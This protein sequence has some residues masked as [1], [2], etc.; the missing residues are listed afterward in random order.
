MLDQFEEFTRRFREVFDHPP[1]G[2]TAGEWLFHLR[3]ETRS[4][5]ALDFLTLAASTG[6]NGRALIDHYHCSLR[7]DVRRELAC[8]DTTLTFDQLVDMSIRLDNLLA[9]RGRPDRGL[10]VPFPS[11]TAAMPMKLGGAALRV[12]GGGA[13]PST[14]CGRRGHTAGR[15]WGGSSRSRG[16]RQGTI[17]SPQV[18]QH[19]AHPEPPV[20]HMFL[21]INFPDFSPRIPSIRH[22]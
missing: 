15:C 16:S 12:T 4:E 1:E 21:L 13:V 6:W 11:T 8:R 7:E 20:A 5:F 9:S 18:S 2:R 10:L 19:Q 17:V 3:Q 14:I 22:S